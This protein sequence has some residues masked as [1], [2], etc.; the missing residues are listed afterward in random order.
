MAFKLPKQAPAGVDILR[1]ATYRNFT[2]GWNVAA[3]ELNMPMKFS[4]RSRNMYCGDDQAQVIRYG[5]QLFADFD[6]FVTDIINAEYYLGFVIVVGSNGVVAASDQSSNVAVLFS[7]EIAAAQAG[8]PNGWSRTSFVSFA[9]FNGQLVI[10]NGV[11][12]PLV[13]DSNLTC[14]YLKDPVDKSNSHVPIASYAI[15]HTE[16]MVLAHGSTISI[17]NKDSIGTFVGASN[18]NDAID[19]DLGPRVK[20]G[21]TTIRGLGSYRDRLVVFFDE[22]VIPLILGIYDGTPSV[23][24][25]S[26]DMPFDG[27]GTVSHRSLVSTGDA[28]QFTDNTGVTQ[29]TRSEF[30]SLLNIGQLSAPINKALRQDLALLS[31]TTRNTRIFAVWNK[32]EN[33]YMLFIPLEDNP[34]GDKRLRGYIYK[35]DTQT[36]VKAWFEFYDWTWTCGFYT[37]N[38]SVFFGRGSRIFLYGSRQNPLYADYIGEQ[39]TFSDGTV[40]T[41]GTGFSPIVSTNTSGVPIKFDWELP[42]SDMGNRSRKKETRYIGFDVTGTADYTVSMYVDKFYFDRSDPGETFTD[43]TLFTDGTGWLRDEPL[44]T[45]ALTMD[46]LGG[47]NLGFGGDPFGE[48]YGGGRIGQ[49]SRSFAWPTQFKIQKLRIQGQTMAPLEIVSITLDYLT[50]S[51][52]A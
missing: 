44:T 34:N 3:N 51:M 7:S 37:P 48:L 6:P 35:A 27:V 50:K 18:P 32:L 39:E 14:T 28:I 43:G 5:T 19:I 15:G 10:T 1:P 8:N 36:N 20:K 45:P 12:K 41:D 30:I 9:K 22:V 52:R 21:D 16:Y 33:M 46:F 11:D 38:G 49:D 17:S 4:H 2:G 24:S 47:D 25:P 26:F 31:S 42:W 29:I 40:F 23:H 13:I